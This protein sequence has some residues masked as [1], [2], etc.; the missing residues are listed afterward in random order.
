ME[1][2]AE[3][4][5]IPVLEAEI[6][7]VLR[8][9]AGERVLDATLGAGGHARALLE[10]TAPGGRLWGLDADQQALA[11]AAA[12]LEAYGERFR[13]VH[14]NFRDLGMICERHGIGEPDVIL[15][16]LG[17]SS[18]QLADPARGFSFRGEGPIDMRMDQGDGRPASELVNR[19][20]EKQLA[21]LLYRL[22]EERRARR[23]ASG[24]VKARTREPI[25]STVRLA[26]IV[27]RAVKP[28][29]KMKTHPATRTFLALRLATNGE[30][31]ALEAGLGQALDRLA[32]GGRLGVISFMSM[33][34]R[35]VK[36]AFRACDGDAFEVL[37]K[38]PL[39]ASEEELRRNRRARSAA[40]RA[41]RKTP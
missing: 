11:R 29:R 18:M 22:G 40:F 32:P 9:A 35:I 20:P 23:I 15:M 30:L 21:E 16:D 14:G 41:V 36:W 38:K 13:A 27:I 12:A 33:E 28:K 6:Q 37:T 19:L 7:Q 39:R 3:I 1:H 8:P 31:E 5:H 34:D 26:E 17:V 10:A 4:E 2:E 24:I 25:R